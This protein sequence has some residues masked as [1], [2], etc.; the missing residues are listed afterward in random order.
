MNIAVTMY[1]INNM[2]GVPPYARAMAEGFRALGENADLLYISQRKKKVPGA[3]KTFGGV[4]FEVIDLDE[5]YKRKMD[6][7]D[8]VIHTIPCPHVGVARHKITKKN[9]K[10]YRNEVNWMDMYDIDSPIYSVIHDSYYEK[11]YPWYD[12]VLDKVDAH[13]CIHENSWL[14]AR[15]MPVKR[16]L[17]PMPI[18]LDDMIHK[19]D[20]SSRERMAVSFNYFKPWKHVDQLVRIVPELQK[21]DVKVELFGSGYTYYHMRNPEL[22]PKKGYGTIW[23]DAMASDNFTYHDWQHDP[24]FKRDW[25]LKSMVTID[26]SDSKWWQKN[27]TRV[28]MEGMKYGSIPIVREAN[29]SMFYNEDNMVI[30]PKGMDLTKAIV[31]IIEDEDKRKEIATRNFNAVKRHDKKRVAE[32]ILNMFKGKTEK[33]ICYED[34]V[35]NNVLDFF[36]DD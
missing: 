36:G 31:N 26:L 20:S 14:Y 6:K 18:D 11:F 10:R 35:S 23:P 8:L 2:G 19:Y 3:T 4:E 33:L 34:A 22:A 29:K 30:V 12:W 21:A 16:F 27:V 24:N 25:Y 5:E 32:D 17:T 28:M 1:G 13:I 9:Y 7:Y 15:R